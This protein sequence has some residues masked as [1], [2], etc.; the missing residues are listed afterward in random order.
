MR[1]KSKS[2]VLLFAMLI[3]ATLTGCATGSSASAAS[4]QLYQ[5]R[6]L[7]LPA[8]QPIPTTQG[9]YRPQT[10][11]LWHSPAE[12]QKLERQVIDLAAALAQ[13]QHAK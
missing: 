6:I 5:P 12:F 10:D 8:G 11:E 2:S 3:S 1:K 7:S 4:R 9:V 13:A